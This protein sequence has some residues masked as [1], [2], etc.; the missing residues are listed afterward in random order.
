[1]KVVSQD[2]GIASLAYIPDEVKPLKGF[3]I[4]TMLSAIAERYQLAKSPSVDD[5]R[6]AGARFNIGRFSRA[7]REVNITELGVFNDALAVTTTDT[8]DA[9][10]VLNDLFAW[11]KGTFHLREPTTPP[12]RFYQSDLVVKFNND[13]SAA[14]GGLSE[15]ISLIQAQMIPSNAR[16]KKPVQFNYIAFGADP[17]GAGVSPE[18][19]VAR[20]LGVPWDL[21]MYFSKAHMTTQNHIRALE[22]LD[23]LLGKNR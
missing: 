2:G 8:D 11:L 23:A 14:F 3:H 15:F 18:F 10:F 16:T 4:P 22:L 17:V 12:I 19:T 20:R 7:D 21:G 1:M 13:P 6:T 9:E 5:A